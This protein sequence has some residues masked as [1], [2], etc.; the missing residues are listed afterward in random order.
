[1]SAMSM[2]PVNVMAH[3]HLGCGE[4]LSQLLP[5]QPEAVKGDAEQRRGQPS[6]RP[7]NLRRCKPRGEGGRR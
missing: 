4:S 2:K 3:L 1:M 5:A 7:D 6:A